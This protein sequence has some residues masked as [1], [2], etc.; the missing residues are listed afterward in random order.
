MPAPESVEKLVD[1]FDT[2]RDAYTS[3]GY[4]ETQVR[5][6]FI[7]PLFKALGWDIDNRQGYA[8]QYKDVIHEDAIKIGGAT[9]APD[10]CFRIG[11]VRKFFL[12]AKKPAVNL[13][14]DPSP[15]YQLRRYAWTAK[16]PLSILTDFEEFIVYD[17]RVQPKPADRASQA[18]VQCLRYTDY[19]DKWD[20]IAGVFSR[21][22]ILRGGFDHFAESK[23][24]KRGTAE[25]DDAFLAE[26]EQWRDVLARNLALRNPALTQRQL[27]TAVQGTIDRLIFLRICE[28][29][30]IEDYGRLQALLNGDHVYERLTHLFRQADD[31]YNSGLFHFKEEKG[32]ASHDGWMLNLAI[33]DKVLKD[34]FRRL[35]YPDSPYEFSVLPAD[36]LGQVYER[37]LGSVIQLTPGHRAKVEQKPEVR[38]AGGVYYTPTYIVDYIVK[39]T[40]GTLL[41]GRKPGPRGTASD[42]R[43]L[44]PA[45]GSGSFLIGAY[46]FL[47]D[48]HL[49]QYLED[50]AKWSKGK[51]PVIYQHHKLGWRLTTAERKRILLNN[52]YG[53]DIDEQA[54]EV[55]KLSLLLK[56]LEEE[57]AE[58]LQRQLALF[59]ERALPDLA[60]NIKC[61][62]SLIG[63]DFYA[64]QQIDAFREDDLYRI[65]AFDWK[66]E[67]AEV[68]SRDSGKGLDCKGLKPLVSPHP[69]DKGLQP[70]ATDTGPIHLWFVTFVT[71]SS[72][73]SER[74]VEF[75]VTDRTGKGLKPLVLSED[76]QIAVAHA[77]FDTASK[78]NYAFV[79]LNV[80]PD[81]VHAV[82]PAPDDTVLSERVCAL[83]SLSARAVNALRNRSNG[84]HVWAQKFNRKRIESDDSLAA[85]TDY[86]AQNHMK[87][88]EWWGERG[89]GLKPLVFHT[90]PASG[91]TPH[92]RGASCSDRE[93][94]FPAIPASGS[95]G[96]KPL[97]Y[98]GSPDKGLQPLARRLDKG[99]Q[100]LAHEASETP[101]LLGRLHALLERGCIP[102]DALCASTPIVNT[103][104][105]DAV[106]GNPPYVR[107]EGL[108]E[109]KD[110]FQRTYSAYTGTADL[111]VPF[112]E[113]AVSLLRPGGYFSYIV[114][115]KWMRANYGKPLRQW[116]A[117]Q[118]LE[119]IIDFG[120]LPVFT[121]ATTYPCIIRIAKTAPGAAF[122]AVNVDTLDFVDIEEHI[123]QR[124]FPVAFATLSPEGWALVNQREQALLDKIRAAGVPLGD[125][126]GGKIY[127]GVLTGLN[128]AFV[129][130][131]AT[132]DQIIADD[133]KSAELIKPFLAG[134]DIK[135]YVPPKASNFL[136][137][138]PNG[139]TRQR[140]GNARDPWAAFS[141]EF[142][143]IAAHLL[144]FAEAAKKRCD[145]GEFW[146][147]LRSCDYYDRFE[148]PK[149][150]FP[151]ISQRGNFVLDAESHYAANTTYF[152]PTGDGYL[153]G[154]L[155]S[156]LLTYYYKESY[157]SYRGGFLRFFEQYLRELPIPAVGPLPRN[158]L[159][160]SVQRM[161]DLHKRLQSAKTEHERTLLQRQ[162]EATDEEI[163]QLVYELYGLTEDE[164]ALVEE[165]VQT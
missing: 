161:L 135:R 72:R 36:I 67:F 49:A 98:S 101:Q 154:L 107:Q 142:T 56:V 32:R 150:F 84:G 77:L 114:A 133:P 39:H 53:V 86:I 14:D 6:E 157:A 20:E 47:L 71:Y 38:K 138:I 145:K 95:K 129:I 96:L 120:D 153:L 116:M 163:D 93:L 152:L 89:K 128:K 102:P 130:D 109:F 51:D 10:Y 159:E 73:V 13:K 140:Y 55:T 105:F 16:M 57:S 35:Y 62:N 69:S 76:E 34:I 113:K 41:E 125:Y 78:N 52:I 63:P 15:A 106:I 127:R 8:E 131:A 126:V 132:R 27:N 162:I 17:T 82:I 139:W 92:F 24:N 68:F 29:R 50:T 3:P 155:N 143:S 164:I 54:V 141:N 48:W 117:R 100:P 60:H 83:K 1:R 5:R 74:M 97:V 87:H 12:E 30:G 46:Q 103:G 122:D 136:L 149:L 94:Q 151:D 112:I 146:W 144:P 156:T 33:D 70:L 88:H 111:Y 28:D 124:R 118:G 22:A 80:L 44:D 42:L 85:I 11:G 115:N 99:L 66:R 45:C 147:E 21:D 123:A 75:G 31:R 65:N 9:K 18:R 104:G 61:G 160:R 64:G 91:G 40:V 43:I 134:R 37:F 2:H 121:T 158:E 79:A 59:H 108:G 110:Y 148:V 81:H 23:T 26:I 25:V 119:E 7:D 90:G 4:N 165:S 58:T 19:L 137:L